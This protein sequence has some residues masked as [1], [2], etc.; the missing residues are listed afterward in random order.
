MQ[1]CV[2]SDTAYLVLPKARSRIAGHFYLNA[3]KTPNKAYRDN[4]NAPILTEYVT[5]KNIV[6]SATK[7]ETAALFHNCTTFERFLDRN[8]STNSL[9]TNTLRARVC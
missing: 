1:L 8:K 5:I 3:F 6:S 4:L 7:A 2:E 9:G